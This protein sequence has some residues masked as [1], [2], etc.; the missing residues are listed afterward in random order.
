M[1][2]DYHMVISVPNGETGWGGVADD[3]PFH[4]FDI[5]PVG[6]HSSCIVI[7]VGWRV[8]EDEKPTRPPGSTV[9]ELDGT[10]AW[11]E[12]RRGTVEHQEMVNEIVSF[13]APVRTV[14]ADG[15]AIMVAPADEVPKVRKI[16]QQLL[17]SLSFKKE[18]PAG[19]SS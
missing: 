4:G 5:F 6:S 19:H 3:A 14:F 1:N 2:D 10:Q 13:S 7:L 16:Y 15:Q 11:L 18:D 17:K 9:V 12:Q 8:E